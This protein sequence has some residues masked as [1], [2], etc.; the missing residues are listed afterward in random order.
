[1]LSSPTVVKSPSFVAAWTVKY[2]RNT[3][4]APMRTPGVVTLCAPVSMD[5][6]RNRG[7]HPPVC[8][9]SVRLD[10]SVIEQGIAEGVMTRDS[11]TGEWVDKKTWHVVMALDP[12]SRAA[13]EAVLAQRVGDSVYLV[14]GGVVISIMYVLDGTIGPIDLTRDSEQEIHQ[15]VDLVTQPAP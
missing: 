11:N 15:L 9:K 12:A 2:S 13:A 6:I 1:M 3:F 10:V 7:E 8:A 4:R 5:H 14:A